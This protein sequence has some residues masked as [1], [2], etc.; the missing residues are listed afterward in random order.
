MF[1][2]PAGAMFREFIP[3]R[4]LLLAALLVPPLWAG[5]GAAQTAVNEP[6][7]AEWAQPQPAP[8]GVPNLY[9]V[10]PNFFRSAQPTAEGFSAL[11]AQYG[12]KTVISMRA[13]HADDVLVRGSGIR[14]VRFPTNTWSINRASVAGALRT[15][16]AEMQT[17]P[18]LLHCQHGADR[19]G[20]I[21]ALYRILYQGW[22]R[23]DAIREMREGGFGYHAV[24][25]NIP[26]YIQKVNLEQLRQQVGVP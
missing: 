4:L 25:G 3:M 7:P 26:R 11:S 16:R 23:Q 10:A 9:Q 14:A 12:I 24:W 21:T 19:T 1:T 15:L 2:S 8:Q 18:V 5:E 22:S 17:G 6:R 20:L 13:N